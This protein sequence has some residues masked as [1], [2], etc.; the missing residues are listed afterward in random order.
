MRAS[1]RVEADNCYYGLTRALIWAALSCFNGHDV[2]V[3]QVDPRHSFFIMS[4]LFLAQNIQNV[5][6]LAHSVF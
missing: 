3:P 5:L 4:F 6:L 2:S 1:L